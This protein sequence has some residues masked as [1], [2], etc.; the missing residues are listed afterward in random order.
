MRHS[1]T[2]WRGRVAADAGEETSFERVVFGEVMFAWTKRRQP[3][4]RRGESGCDD[5]DAT[6]TQREEGR[7]C[8]TR[9]IP[10][11]RDISEREGT[12]GAGK[13]DGKARMVGAA[14]ALSLDET[15]GHHGNGG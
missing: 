15:H 4:P 14:Q 8:G 6:E 2:T 3:T 7:C 9:Y 5:C 10:R 1:A 11:S 12:T 13:R